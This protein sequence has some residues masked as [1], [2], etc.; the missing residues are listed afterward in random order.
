MTTTKNNILLPYLEDTGLD[1]KRLYTP[2]EWTER[3]RHYIKRIHNIDIKPA[4]SGETMPTSNEWTTKEPEIRQDFIWGAGPSAIETITK[5]EFNTDPDTINTEKL[6]QLFKDYYM[7]KRNTYHSRGDFFWAK[8]E[9]NE[10]PEEHW[11]KLVSLEKNCEFKDIKQEDLLISKFITSITDKKLREKLIREKTLDLKTTMDLVTQDSYEK[12]HRQST[13]PPALAKEKEIKEEPIQKIQPQN[14]QNPQRKTGETSKTNNCG[15]CGQKNWSPLHKCPAK[16]VECNNCH[17]MGHFARVCRSKNNNTRK[18][19]I[20]YLEETY[21]EEDE[22]EP[23]EIQ[24][25]TQINRVLP[26]ENDN[27]GIKLKVNG[28]YQ[29]FTI[30][31]G[32]PVTIMPNNPKLYNPRDIKP[33]KER[34]QDVN[35][36]EIKFLGKIWADIE[37]NGKTTKLPILITQRDDITPLLGVNWLKRLPITINKISLDEPTNQSENIYT[38]FNK[39]FESNHTIKNIE[40]KI[41]IKPGCYPIQQKA[42]PVPYHLQKDVKNELDRL[43]KSGHLERLETI[44][45]DCFVSPVVITVKKDKTVKIALDA[46]KLNESCIKKRP[47]MPNMEELLNQISAELSKNDHDPIWISVIDLDYAYGQMKLAPETSRH[48]NF[49][50]TG[51]TINGY[52]R[53]LKGFYGPADIPTIFQEKIDRT[54][55]HQTPVWLDDIIVVTRGTKEEHTRKLYSVLTK[56]EDEGYRA[57]KKKS[58]F[59]QKETIW[60][61]HTISQDGIRPNKE[62]TDAINKLEP[63]TNTK[64]LKS[65]LGAIQYFAK[66][67]PNLSE[68]TDNMRQ[69]LKKGTKWEWTTERNSDFNKIKNE[70]T[71][72]PCLAHYNGNKENIVTTDACKTGLGIALWQKQGNGELKPIAYASRYLNDA[73]KKYS[74]GE[75]ELLAV[76]WGLERFRFHLY[77]KQVQLFSDHQALEPLLKRNKMNKQ[78]SARLTR[79]LDR[80]NHFDICLKHTAGKEIKFTDFISRNPT[81]NPEPEEN[82]EEEFVINAIAQLITVNARIGRIFNQSNLTNTDNET[83]MLGTRSLIE[84]RRRQTNNSHTHFNYRIEQHSAEIDNSEMN[85]ND[86][87]A[88]FFRMDGQLRYHWG[89]DDEIMNIINR[90]EKS[91]E[92]TNLVKR[93]IELARP[94]AMRPQWNKNLGREIYIP[95]RPEEDERREIKRIDI[96]LKRKERESHIGGGYFQDF[97]D[98]IPQRQPQE[99]Q[100]STNNETNRDTESTTSNNSE[101]AVATHEPGAYP[102]IPVQE[103]RDGPI[104]EIAVHYVRINRIVEQK[105]KRNKQQEDNIRSAELD[106]M[107][108]LE[109]LIKETAADPDLIELNCCIEDN[110]MEQIPQNYKTVAKKLTHRWGIIM[111]DDRIII[112]KSLRYAALNALH[113]GHP[114]INKMCNDAAIFWWPNM[115]EDIE[116]K[117]KTCSACLNAGKNLKFQLP[118]TEKTKIEP[119][120]KPGEEIQIDFTGNLHNKKLTS[121]PFI[122]VAVDKN[123]RWPV[124]KICKNTNHETVISFLNEYINV[125][126]VPKRIKSDRGGAFI[127]KEYKEFC[128]SQNIDRNYGT[129][130]LHT[131]TGLVERTIQS[132]KNLILANLEDDQNLRESVNRALYVLRFTVHSETKK[133]PFESHFGREPRTKLLN[134][135]NSVLVDS[136]DLSVYITRNSTGEITDHLVMSKK[137][138]VEPKFRRGMTFSQ[139]KKPTS[140]VST[141]KFQYPFKFYEKNYKKGSLESKFKKKIQTA[142]SGTKHTVTT[143]KNKILHRKLISNP[144]PFQQATTAPMKRMNTR[145]NTADQPTCSKTLDTTNN[146]GAPCIY[147]RKEPPKPTSHERSEDWVKRRDPPRNNKGQ[148]TSPN[149]NTETDLNLSIISDDEFDCYNKS[150]GKPI[151]TNP[152]DE[153]QLLPKENNLTPEQGRYKKKNQTKPKEPVRRS[154]RLPFAK[155]TEKLGG[156]PYHTNNNKKKLTYNDNLLQETTTETTESN[157]EG[158]NRPM[159]KDEEEIR[160]IRPYKMPQQTF[161]GPFRRR[162]NVTS[163]QHHDLQTHRNIRH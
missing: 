92:T 17:K 140:S 68:K 66:F 23:E 51:E 84:T 144:L 145:N 106:F 100:Q 88:R 19:K 85:N 15:F 2:K 14:K 28:R 153:L 73:E 139:T 54:L 98:E 46:R 75:L 26:D 160:I 65:F 126:G 112:P 43:I 29:N 125:Y 147:S 141:N 57:S 5:G 25:I 159:R 21:N 4:L 127:S 101:D 50:M 90:R 114:G 129:A 1:G 93:R 9:E 24:Q 152:D 63:P 149:K 22:S 157:E 138:T 119:P 123:S 79:W 102:A 82:Y 55:G 86:N 44:E 36:N 12:R 120:K 38:K 74:I 163:Y 136:K 134:L 128:R 124:A 47:H 13:I 76:V 130:N 52:Y 34:Y 135:K 115:R 56:L 131:G 116:K 95:R 96:Q 42:R 113:F 117:S 108:D 60:L 99:Q 121:H 70:L 80:L 87:N 146:N 83:N 58:K 154:N 142:V 11:R 45:E 61:G 78:Y 33:L 111:V 3:L 158:N 7:P 18:Q 89:A 53:F 97:G 31:T 10:T 161:T 151:Q 62:K 49:A 148:F 155:Q 94:G 39:L 156:V 6:I 107:L 16:T 64:T 137:K 8:Q 143:D 132:L 41:Q 40:V 77:G 133:T 81:E 48:C 20:N 118:T 32:S 27:Y 71:T 104:E 67:I 103:Y 69:L 109:T 59:Y 122:L 91:P 110:N 72:L 150:E 30:D 162:G 35:K 37:H 105:A